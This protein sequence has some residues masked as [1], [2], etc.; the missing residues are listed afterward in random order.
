VPTTPPTGAKASEEILAACERAGLDADASTLTRAMYASDASLYRV[1]PEVVVRARDV[2]DISAV[3]DVS[4]SSGTPLTMRGAGTSIAGNA[5]GSGIVVDTRRLNRFEIDADSASAT[6]QP[7]VVHASLQRAARAQGL[8]FGPDPSTHSRCTI[9][10]MI[11]NNACGSRA[12]GYG[13]TVD[14]VLAL[15]ALL[16]D[17]SPVASVSGRIAEV[18]D[19][20]LD[21][22][23]TEFG[24]FG[25]QVSGYSMEHLLPERGRRLERF[26]VGSEGTLAVVT[27]ATVRLVRDEPVRVLAV[28]GFPDLATAAD[29]VPSLLVL[30][31]TAC[32]GLDRR[33]V[34]LTP[35]H[36][37][38]PRGDAWLLVEFTGESLGDAESTAR[39][40]L[41]VAGHGVVVSDPRQQAALWRIREDTAGLAAVAGERPGLAGWEDAA[42]P[43]ER[44][45]GY[46]REF[47]MLI[48]DFG[49]EGAPYGH[50]GEG[51][52][53]IRIDFD[54]ATESGRDR[55]RRFVESAAD[56][57][58]AHGGSLSGEHGD[59]R[60]RSELLPRMYGQEAL[61]L[62][63][64]VKHLCD[65]N[66]LLNPG[67]LVDPQPVD[68]SLR[69]ASPRIDLPT[70][71]W[72]S[73]GAL[74]AEIDRCTGVGKCVAPRPVGVMCPSFAVTGEEKDGTRGRARLLQEM[75][76]GRLVQG[77]WDAPEVQEALDLC[78][79]CKACASECPTGVDMASLR[80]EALSW[81][82]AGKKRPRIH[83]TLGRLP[84]WTLIVPARLAN[85]GLRLAP[86]LAARVS[87]VDPRRTLPELAVRPFHRSARP[88]ARPADVVP[89]VVLWVDTFTNRF[90]PSVAAAAVEVLESAGLAVR[91]LADEGCCGL[92][93]LS[94][95]QIDEGREW[96]A[97]LVGTLAERAGDTPVVG[98]EPS[99]LGVLRHDAPRLLDPERAA[100]AGRVRTLAEFLS[101]LEGWSAPDRTGAELVVQPHCHHSA[102]LGWQ[103]DRRL[104]TATGAR[105][106]EVQG[107][108]GMAGDFG[109]DPGHYDLSVAIAQRSLLPALESGGDSCVAVADG[110]SCRT[111][112]TDLAGRRSVHLAELL[113]PSWPGQSESSPF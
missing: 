82:Y 32:E 74:A 21:V 12:L 72:S 111:Q 99:C 102:V 42:V 52:V 39:A 33:L 41:T 66:N 5:V 38:L 10:G 18:V 24:R 71:Q 22:I 6:V 14:N 3:L 109:M 31:P 63:G 96:L 7:G 59:G 43:P 11:G 61:A 50:L 75:V 85:L 97:E 70:R 68:R 44:L 107:C 58:A 55:Y 8:R 108:C 27:G 67:V 29:L 77:G 110:F 100:F 13:R 76:D 93:W 2:D 94:T 89:D 37:P 83:R 78:L 92:T 104:L 23:R 80:S 28:M 9:G 79:A 91:V 112:I 15:S 36:P 16:P 45:G 46:L 48:R 54:P 40:C 56:L 51:C 90:A 106:T 103:A 30:R 84:W 98:L 57:V 95:G 1:V 49:Y 35:N 34:D 64:A 53:H 47:E 62:F 113:S 73:P 69:R 20:H 26:L 25:R 101:G 17:G 19:A 86:R 105:L 87:G 65:P 81:R 4:R 60:A 88:S